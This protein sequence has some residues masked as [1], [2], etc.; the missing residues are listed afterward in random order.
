VPLQ[1]LLVPFLYTSP[2]QTLYSRLGYTRRIQEG[3]QLVAG[4]PGSYTEKALHPG[5]LIQV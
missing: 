5:E 3:S 1:G 2:I 4:R